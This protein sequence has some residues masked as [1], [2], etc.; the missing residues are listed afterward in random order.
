MSPWRERLWS[1][2]SSRSTVQARTEA[3][4]RHRRRLLARG[5]VSAAPGEYC[6]HVSQSLQTRT[7][8]SGSLVYR[9]TM[10]DHTTTEAS[11]EVEKMV[12]WLGT[13]KDAGMV[14]L[15]K[16][17]GG[18]PLFSRTVLEKQGGEAKAFA[19][20]TG[21]PYAGEACRTSS[22]FTIL[23]AGRL[24]VMSNADGCREVVSGRHVV[25][26]LH[27]AEASPRVACGLLESI[28]PGQQISG[29]C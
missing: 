7:D 9:A 24:P 1:R 10:T 11:D 13:R 6:G 15:I 12:H 14:V 5:V 28:A 4:A 22:G 25:R 29:A 23:T 2:G 26:F 19:R 27:D 16:P 8:S 18:R 21:M 20:S 3:F 17:A